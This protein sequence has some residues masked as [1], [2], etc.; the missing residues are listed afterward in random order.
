MNM[1]PKFYIGSAAVCHASYSGSQV[2]SLQKISQLSHVWK[3]HSNLY[4]WAPIPLF[5]ERADYRCLELLLS[6]KN[7]NLGSTTLSSVSFSIPERVF[8]KNLP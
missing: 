2:Q 7:G 8:S 6:Y 3:E 4:V 5:V 1:Q